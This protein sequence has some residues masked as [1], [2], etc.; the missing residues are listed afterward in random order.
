MSG[1]FG[2]GPVPD[3]STAFIGEPK[4]GIRLISFAGQPGGEVL[5]DTAQDD[6][7]NILGTPGTYF[8]ELNFKCDLASCVAI[9]DLHHS[10]FDTAIV[11]SFVTSL[12]DGDHDGDDPVGAPE[13][14]TLVLVS[15]GLLG[16]V[17]IKNCSGQHAN[18]T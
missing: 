10:V 2:S 17:L 15:A 12:G 3:S 7:Q 6:A 5:L 9:D 11:T 4:F 8:T 1:P 14:G 18:Y 13:P 16:L